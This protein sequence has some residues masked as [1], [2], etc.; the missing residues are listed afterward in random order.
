MVSLQ[1]N[2]TVRQTLRK[3]ERG[4]D[5]AQAQLLGG[6]PVTTAQQTHRV[7][8]PDYVPT[9][10]DRG[11]VPTNGRAFPLPSRTSSSLMGGEKP[12]LGSA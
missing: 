5:A 8:V 9:V 4:Q 12:G 1:S 11:S 2:T 7:A 10:P 3:R 6:S